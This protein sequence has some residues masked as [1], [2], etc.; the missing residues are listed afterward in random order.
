MNTIIVVIEG[1][2]VQ[3]VIADQPA[4]VIVLDYDSEDDP[5]GAVGVFDANDLAHLHPEVRAH[6]E[7]VCPDI[8]PDAPQPTS[9]SMGEQPRLTHISQPRMIHDDGVARV[10]VDPARPTLFDLG[11]VD[12]EPKQINTMWR[13]DLCQR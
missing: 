9:E 13:D 8:L 11:T 4:Q 6:I 5:K 10:R 3:E 1:G 7:D 12:Q 2:V